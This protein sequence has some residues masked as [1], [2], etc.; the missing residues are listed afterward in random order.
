MFCSISHEL[1]SPLNHISGMHSLLKTKLAQPE[2]VHLLNIA[3]SSTEMLKLKIDDI[4]EKIGGTI[5]DFEAKIA[6]VDVEGISGGVK[7]TVEEATATL[8]TIRRVVDNSRDNIYRSTYSLK[9]TLRNLEEF[10]AIIREQPSL[11]LS[12]KKHKDRPSPED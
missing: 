5:S 2:Q 12:N 3:E 10:S 8:A 1:R 7:T 6:K 11:L 4:L 9:R